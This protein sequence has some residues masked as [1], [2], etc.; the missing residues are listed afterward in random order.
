[1]DKKPADGHRIALDKVAAIPGDIVLLVGDEP[2]HAVVFVNEGPATVYIGETGTPTANW[3]YLPA[4]QG[5]T[6]NYTKE[7]WWA[8]TLS[9]SGTISGF[10]VY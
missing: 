1:M 9:G 10:V 4:D 5:F 3:M 2:R 8:Y 6:D 7:S